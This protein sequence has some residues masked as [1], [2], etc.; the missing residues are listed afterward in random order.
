MRSA[1][2]EHIAMGKQTWWT[3]RGVD[4]GWTGNSMLLEAKRESMPLVLREKVSAA[5]PSCWTPQ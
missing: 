1:M 5:L 4:G 2:G 3:G